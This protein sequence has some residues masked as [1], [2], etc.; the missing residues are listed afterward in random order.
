MKN[1][2][3]ISSKKHFAFWRYAKFRISFPSFQNFLDSKGEM[4]GNTL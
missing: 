3:F 4:E 2:L 1:I